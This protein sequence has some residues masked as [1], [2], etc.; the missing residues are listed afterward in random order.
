M[1]AQLSRLKGS[2]SINFHRLDGTHAKGGAYPMPCGCA[3]TQTCVG[4]ESFAGQAEKRLVYWF[5]TNVPWHD[6][7][8]LSPDN[9]NGIIPKEDRKGMTAPHGDLLTT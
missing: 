9:P 1:S 8:R 7:K 6:C 5:E 2:L 3:I 4:T